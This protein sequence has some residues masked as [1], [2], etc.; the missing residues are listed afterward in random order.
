[1]ADATWTVRVGRDVPRLELTDVRG[2]GPGVAI[3]AGAGCD[4]G[5]GAGFGGAGATP[6]KPTSPNDGATT[7]SSVV[8]AATATVSAELGAA[9]A[10]ESDIGA[11]EAGTASEASRPPEAARTAVARTAGWPERLSAEVTKVWGTVG[12]TGAR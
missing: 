9:W 5:F 12:R 11:A 6:V 7:G 3:G 8:G 1:V 10:E 4:T 2:V